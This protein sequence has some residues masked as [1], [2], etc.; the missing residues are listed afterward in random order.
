M[1]FTSEV[2]SPSWFWWLQRN[3]NVDN[4]LLINPN[5]SLLPIV[6]ISQH[7]P[8]HCYLLQIA[9]QCPTHNVLQLDECHDAIHTFG[10]RNLVWNWRSFIPSEEEQKCYLPSVIDKNT[11]SLFP[12][13]E[14][15][16]WEFTSLLASGLN[17]NL[18]VVVYLHWAQ[19]GSLCFFWLNIN[20]DYPLDYLWSFTIA[21]A[22][23]WSQI[24]DSR[25]SETRPVNL[26]VS[27]HVVKAVLMN[28]KWQSA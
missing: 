20:L 19:K 15:S 2:T 14:Y 23:E 18:S 28:S 11:G 13:T 12:N 27:D 25:V 22:Q 21:W 9:S 4:S 1:R 26:W 16:S 24:A 10:W 7:N 6:A 17:Q 3:S 5:G 8:E